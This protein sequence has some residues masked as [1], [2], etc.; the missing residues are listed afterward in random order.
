MILVTIAITTAV[1]WNVA[2]YSLEKSATST[3]GV[4]QSEDG[5]D[6]FPPKYLHSATVQKMVFFIIWWLLQY[7]IEISLT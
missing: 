3:C 2:T 6:K 1:F 4:F 5:S 7:I